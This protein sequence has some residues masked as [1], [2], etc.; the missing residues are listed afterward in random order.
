M[1]FL[2]FMLLVTLLVDSVRVTDSH[3]TTDFNNNIHMEFW[4]WFSSVEPTRINE[5]IQCTRQNLCTV[6]LHTL[7]L[8]ASSHEEEGV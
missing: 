2:N 1:E 4:K 7:F 3:A 5:D 8:K 6:A